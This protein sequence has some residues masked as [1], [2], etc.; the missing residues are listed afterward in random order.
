MT[1]IFLTVRFKVKKYL[2]KKNVYSL[3]S[4]HRNK[5]KSI[6]ILNSFMRTI[7]VLWDNVRQK[8]GHAK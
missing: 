7:K 6:V 4:K 1:N 2:F 5:K 3:V 8:K